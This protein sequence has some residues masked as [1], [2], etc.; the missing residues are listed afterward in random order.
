M[1]PASVAQLNTPRDVAVDST[2]SLYSADYVHD[3]IRKVTPDGI[4]RTVAGNG[5]RLFN[6]DGGQATGA[7][8]AQPRAVAVDSAGNIFIADWRN[9]RIR[10]VK[11]Q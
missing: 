6:G 9:G 8:L 4:I 5:L 2:G 7:Q 10:K 3:R 1:G 11:I